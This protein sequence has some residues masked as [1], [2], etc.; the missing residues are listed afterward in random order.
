M[1]PADDHVERV[2]GSKFARPFNGMGQIGPRDSTEQIVRGTLHAMTYRTKLRP[3]YGDWLSDA[4]P[5]G[6]RPG[7]TGY[8]A[9]AMSPG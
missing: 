1:R 2:E 8:R 9:T 4:P 5:M 3:M 6:H 7:N